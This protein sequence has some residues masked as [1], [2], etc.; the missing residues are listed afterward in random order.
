MASP[1]R[2]VAPSVVGVGVDLVELEEFAST[3]LKRPSVLR[4]V[5]T[6]GE[7]AWC[8][9]GPRRVERLAARFAAKEAAFKAAGTGWSGGVTWRDA[10]VVSARGVAPT[11]AVRGV[12][13]RHAR[14][15]GGVTFH[16]SLSHS[17]QYA[18]AMVL[19]VGA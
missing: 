11:L 19:L 9:K 4:R 8:A 6:P 16:L 12:L 7:L 5:F 3:V 1:P 13:K 2:K 15:L 14:A 10:E 18:V 17:G